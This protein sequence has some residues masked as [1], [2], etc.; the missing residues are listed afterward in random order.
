MDTKPPQCTCGS[1]Q[2]G[3]IWISDQNR[4]Q[5][6]KCLNKAY[7]DLA[8]ISKITLDEDPLQGVRNMNNLRKEQ[9]ETLR[10]ATTALKEAAGTLVRQKSEQK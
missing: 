4:Y 10:M 7:A 6:G 3:L 8:E 9:D 5:C 1:K 2:A